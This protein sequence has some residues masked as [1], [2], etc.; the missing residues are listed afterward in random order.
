MFPQRQ[1]TRRVVGDLDVTDVAGAAL[2]AAMEP[3]LSTGGN[4]GLKEVLSPNV[5]FIGTGAIGELV[6][7]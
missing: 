2:G 7:L 6:A 1:T 3:A 4:S 5:D